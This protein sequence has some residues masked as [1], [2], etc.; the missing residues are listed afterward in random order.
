[1]P[2]F[3]PRKLLLITCIAGLALAAA[4][5]GQA[6]RTDV[7]EQTSER[8]FTQHRATSIC[9]LVRIRVCRT[10]GALKSSYISQTPIS[11][12]ATRGDNISITTM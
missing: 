1:M 12:M 8:T 6:H 11:E 4:S 5:I 3:T 10:L 7:T 2:K 9:P